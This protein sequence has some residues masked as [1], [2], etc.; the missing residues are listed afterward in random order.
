M[1]FLQV[2]DW[3]HF[4]HYKDRNPPW[5]KFYTALLDDYEFSILPELTQLALVRIW[6]LAARQ[7]NRLRNDPVWIQ[8]RAGLLTPPD[9]SALVAG[10]WLEPLGTPAR[11]SAGKSAGKSAPECVPLE[12]DR[13][14]KKE[15][16]KDDQPLASP[17]DKLPEIRPLK[18]VDD[19]DPE[20]QQKVREAEEFLSA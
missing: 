2:R 5:I 15:R 6:L 4:Q 8:H 7:N 10:G 13:D 12:R 14:R 9:L 16:K 17:E 20:F 1:S 18:L 19:T 3:D 11:K